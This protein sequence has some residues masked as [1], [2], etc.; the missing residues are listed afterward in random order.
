MKV[1]F[2]GNVNGAISISNDQIVSVNGTPV[3]NVTPAA[4]AAT[5][6]GFGIEEDMCG[7][8]CLTMEFTPGGTFY[9]DVV[10]NGVVDTYHPVEFV[11][12]RPPVIRK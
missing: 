12:G 5:T 4:Y 11:G 7:T 1:A 9:I 8:K 6:P 2:I 10:R 3:N